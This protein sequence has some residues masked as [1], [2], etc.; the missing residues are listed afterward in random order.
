[1]H[2]IAFILCFKIF[3]PL[4]AR[5]ESICGSLP[6]A[7]QGVQINKGHYPSI[8]GH[9]IDQTTPASVKRSFEVTGLYPLN[10]RAVDRSQLVTSTSQVD[11]NKC[12]KFELY[13][14]LFYS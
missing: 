9:A 8:L 1:M 14:P 4:K 3:G 10:K 5:F 11:S 12:S 6:Y 7:R 13:L 2:Y